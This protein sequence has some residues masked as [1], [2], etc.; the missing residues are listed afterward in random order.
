MDSGSQTGHEDFSDIQNIRPIS[1]MSDLSK[2]IEKAILA[3][4]IVTRIVRFQI[5]SPYNS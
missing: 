5:Q 4:L 3:R 2:V 1:L